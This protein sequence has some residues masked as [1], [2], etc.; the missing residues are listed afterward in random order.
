[1]RAIFSIYNEKNNDYLKTG[2]D[3]V[4]S[5]VEVTSQY[6]HDVIHFSFIHLIQHST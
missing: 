5:V 3:D 4:T 6:K 1:M 2:L